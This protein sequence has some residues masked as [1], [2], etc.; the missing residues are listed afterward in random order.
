MNQH[1]SHQPVAIKQLE[2][3]AQLE[4]FIKKTNE[5]DFIINQ[6]NNTLEG[7]LTDIYA[8]MAG[9]SGIR[10]LGNTCYFNSILQCLRHAMPL[11]QYLFGP[12]IKNVLLRN[13]QNHSV[14]NRTIALLINYVKVVS[15]LWENSNGILS[16]IS[17]KHLFGLIYPQFSGIDQHDAHECLVTLLMSLHDTL[18][19][20]V[21]YTFE[22]QIITD[23]DKHIKK[24][25]KDWE[26]H[27]KN[28]HS[29]I[30]DIFS[31]QQQ[32]KTLCPNCEHISYRYDPFVDFNVPLPH[33]DTSFGSPAS[34]TLYDCLGQ[35]TKIN[36][37]DID[38]LYHCDKCN[39]NSQATQIHSIW[40]LPNV[41]TIKLNRFK[42]TVQ[43][44]KYS[45][46]KINDFVFYPLNDLD[47]SKYISSPIDTNTRYKLFGISCHRGSPDMGHYYSYCLNQIK[48]QWYM[49]NDD[50][51]SEVL[52]YDDLVT[53]DAYILF[54]QK[55]T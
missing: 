26:A 44:G 54:Y 21:K 42:Y 14:P 22:G 4:T 30:L 51:A 1:K 55:Q 18:S 52:D 37:L 5:D 34:Y 15:T 10:N 29:I 46:D 39:S 6:I 23:L 27:Y 50:S 11:N 48:N 41:L 40:K 24:A 49:F 36:K 25:H 12:K 43:N 3:L 53:D 33:N 20:N 7:N 17:L 16:P 31:G 2:Y 13:Q 45:Q 35:F 38:N 9:D 32:T 19:R 28:R 47:M 8:K